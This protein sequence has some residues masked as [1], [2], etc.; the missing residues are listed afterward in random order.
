MLKF[1]LGAIRCGD[2]YTIQISFADI[3]TVVW[4]ENTV[5]VVHEKIYRFVRDPQMPLPIT[6]H[7]LEMQLQIKLKIQLAPIRRKYILSVGYKKHNFSHNTSEPGDL[8]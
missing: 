4:E 2:S 5:L 1:G 6:R 7:G 8:P 3:A